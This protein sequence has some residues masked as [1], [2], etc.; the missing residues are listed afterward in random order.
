MEVGKSWVVT[1]SSRQGREAR[2]QR[3]KRLGE[4]ERARSRPTALARS[5]DLMLKDRNY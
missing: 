2:V 5:L 3:A 1:E 4:M